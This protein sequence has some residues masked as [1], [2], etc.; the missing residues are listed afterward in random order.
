MN[1][2]Q[3]L[4]EL[5]SQGI[6]KKIL[7]VLK[8]VDRKNFIPQDQKEAAYE[9]IP[10]PIGHSATISQPYTVAFMLQELEL[11]EGLKVLEIGTG[12]GWNAALLSKLVGSKGRVFTTEII[13][14]LVQFAKKNLKS[15][16]NVKV[17]LTQNSLGYKKAAPYDRLIQTA[18]SPEP[19]KELIAQLKLNGIYLAPI[20]PDYNQKML[21]IRKLK[22]KLDYQSL[23]DFIFVP[24]RKPKF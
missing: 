6:S 12:S 21:K 10:L 3:L 23:G 13:P 5:E 11:R 24:L 1:L 15:Y 2:P 20:G 9:N 8:K 16:K 17:L 4:K 22:N 19:V 14:E 7:A 18:A